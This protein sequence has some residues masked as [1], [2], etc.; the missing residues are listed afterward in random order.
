[1][2]RAATWLKIALVLF[3]MVLIGAGIAIRS[4]TH[5]PLPQVEGEVRLPGADGRIEVIRDEHG[6]PSIYASTDKDLLRAQGYVHAQD[7]FFQMDYR[8]HV[9]AG[10]LSELVGDNEE[11]RQ[12]D[13]VIRALGWRE[14]A[15]VEWSRLDEDT[16][17]L[18]EAY[19]EGV[20]T[21]IEGRSPKQLATEY[22]VLGLTL[23]LPEIEPWDPV[24]S[25]AWLKAMAW[26]LK[27]N[28][29]EEAARVRAYAS[30]PD[31]QLVE[32]LF[33]AFDYE[34]REPI[35]VGDE[36]TNLAPREEYPLADPMDLAVA[37]SE[38]AL[39]AAY[40]PAQS[41]KAMADAVHTAQRALDG[42]PVLLGRGPSVGSNSFVIAGEHTE[43]GE[44]LL[45]ND[46]HLTISY[47]SV[48]H[49]VALHCTGE[50]T[51]DVAGFSFAGMPGVVIGRNA[52][53]AWGLTN[54]GGDVTDFVLEK[55][56]GDD[57]YERD[58]EAVP[59]E[60]RT[61][62]FEV[63]GAIPFEVEMRRSVH[64]PI[65]SDLLIGDEAAALPG[66]PGD[67]SVAL[68]WTAL[69]P[70]ESARAVIALNRASTPQEIAEA[71][72]LFEVPAQN[73][74]FVT[75]DGHIGYQA[76]GR[77]PIRPAITD[78][79]QGEA[80]QSG[81]DF[82]ADGRWP[83]P[84]WD[85]S[86]DWQ[87]YWAP[88]DMPASL[89]PPAGYIV[90]A[91]QAVTEADLGPYLGSSHDA[92]FRADQMAKEIA[93]RIGRG[94]K[95]SVAAAEE[96]ML[97]DGSPFGEHLGPW[98]V[99]AP[100]ASDEA[101]KAQEV[102]ADWIDRGAPA[103]IDEAGMTIMSAT[104]A[105]LLNLTFGSQIEGFK[106]TNSSGYLQAYMSFPKDSPWWDDPATEQIE[107]REAMMGRALQAAVE[108]LGSRLAGGPQSWNW[109]Q[110]HRET[111]THDILGGQGI[112]APIR[113]YFN[114][115]PRAVPGG[116][117]IPNAM[118][119]SPELVDGHADFE[120]GPGPSMR[121]V[122]DM[123]GQDRWIVSS[124]VSGHPASSHVDD[125]LDMWARGESLLWTFDKPAKGKRNTLVLRP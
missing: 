31:A 80:A 115:L 35:L 112:P 17:A 99:E 2:P 100:A 51:L 30:V 10:R 90:A 43:S 76:P 121:M 63:A 103:G 107:D 84:G 82:G 14:I 92:G 11:A 120:V 119:F 18:Y 83:R 40:R 23:D 39:P 118:G 1:M 3:V 5:A 48:W 49:Q 95:I 73:I 58:G 47:P 79:D 105:H 38:L 94:E 36:G 96:I 13:I 59:Y 21:Y 4:I 7:R 60:V 91:N 106:A 71:A 67:I 26:D 88:E 66:A 104:Y 53:I 46:P 64:G 6:I 97:L 72:A 24:D 77:F 111:P 12:A 68:Q 85:S 101:A 32:E 52:D 102:L 61:E 45:A 89:D 98:V 87:G 69:S 33:P 44:P 125:Q 93:N 15:E 75:R 124:G 42:L 22:S 25:L 8:R 78:V 110:V 28:L 57:T 116:S 19:A 86:Y 81:S 34:A 50:C 117:S 41:P 74:V 29:D 122:V 108:D 9:T 113:N 20:N 16:R 56:L 70:G 54:L 27:N 114:G 62:I 37:G 109:G 65:I 123:G 55:N